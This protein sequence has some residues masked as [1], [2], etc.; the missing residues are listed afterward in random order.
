MGKTSRIFQFPIYI[1]IYT[2][3]IYIDTFSIHVWYIGLHEGLIFIVN[4]GIIYHTWMVCDI[5][6]ELSDAN[7]SGNETRFP[8]SK[9]MERGLGI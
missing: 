3:N 2:Y 9:Y 6:L 4:V 5:Y 7:I 1:Y 8:A